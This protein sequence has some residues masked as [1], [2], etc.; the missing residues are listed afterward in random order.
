MLACKRRAGKSRGIR[1]QGRI[2]LISAFLKDRKGSV[3]IEFAFVAAVFLTI[4]FAIMTY[5]FH[6]ATRIA[7]SHAVSEG[8]RA[9]VAGLNDADREELARNAIRNAIESYGPLVRWEDAE[10]IDPNWRNTDTGRVGDI[11]VIYNAA[12]RFSFLPFVPA[13]DE[14]IRVSTTYIVTDPDG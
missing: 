5:G 2:P 9:A 1:F 6:F 7:L 12:G 11:G 3:A 10:T 8:G 13:P 14:M 4:L